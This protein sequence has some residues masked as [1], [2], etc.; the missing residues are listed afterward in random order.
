MDLSRCLDTD[1][2]KPQDGSH[3]LGDVPTIVAS[4]TSIVS[5]SNN[6]NTKRGERTNAIPRSRVGLLN[7]DVAKSFGRPLEGRKT[8]CLSRRGCRVPGTR[9]HLE[10]R[11]HVSLQTN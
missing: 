6:L 4:G 9:P 3:R 10:L 1:A 8:W 5:E 2:A 7:R 11:C